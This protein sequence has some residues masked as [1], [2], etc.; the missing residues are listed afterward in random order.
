[1]GEVS[2]EYREVRVSEE[3]I[4]LQWFSQKGCGFFHSSHEQGS[5][6]TNRDNGWIFP[7]L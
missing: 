4:L 3:L 2:D 7:A 6:S 5:L 1:M